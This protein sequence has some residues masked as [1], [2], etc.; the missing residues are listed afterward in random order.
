MY[1]NYT[2]KTHDGKTIAGFIESESQAAAR[3]QLRSQ[4]VFLLTMDEAVSPTAASSRSS[5]LNRGRVSRTDLLMATSQMAIMCKSGVELAEAIHAVGDHAT[6]PRLKKAFAEIHSDITDGE[7]VSTAMERQMDVFG[8]TYVASIRAGET[9]GN[10]VDVLNRLAELLRNEI[11]LWSTIRGIMAYP[12]VLITI[13][14]VVTMAIML[15]VLPQFAT[16]FKNMGVPA[17]PLTQALLSVGD[18][19][20]SNWIWLITG[21]SATA[22]S[23]YKFSKTTYFRRRIDRISLNGAVL[24]RAS[25]PILTG[26]MLRLLG[27][28]LQSGIPLLDSLQLCRTSIRNIYFHDLFDRLEEAVTNGHGVGKILTDTF[29]IPPG[30]AQ[31]VSTAERTGKLGDVMNMVGEFYEDDGERK[32]RDIVKLLEPAIIVILGIVVGTIVI[33]VVLPLLDFSS[34]RGRH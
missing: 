26:R 7:A 32:L 33:S 20:R 23:V 17:P 30:A 15:F 1:F 21:V 6:K 24:N 4:G 5:F 3:S 25:R 19:M 28:M 13:S 29:F 16:V 22:F 8:P 10:I 27:T 34:I 9:A 2:A 31:M 11:R 18:F 14:F 12:I